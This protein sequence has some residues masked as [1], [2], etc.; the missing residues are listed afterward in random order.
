MK[1]VIEKTRPTLEKEIRDFIKDCFLKFGFRELEY[2]PIDI[3]EEINSSLSYFKVSKS[4]ISDFLKYDCY[5]KP[6]SVV[7]KYKIYQLSI[8]TMT[9]VQEDVNVKLTKTQ[10]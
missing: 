1:D 2:C 5:M 9:N 7:K 6:S 4:Q 8:N 3:A 10:Q